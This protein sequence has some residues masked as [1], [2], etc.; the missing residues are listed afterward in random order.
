[1]KLVEITHKITW[2][3]LNIISYAFKSFSKNFGEYI[4][5]ENPSYKNGNI[6][7]KYLNDTWRNQFIKVK[8]SLLE[9]EKGFIELKKKR[10]LKDRKVKIKREIEE[11]FLKPIIVSTDEI[12]Q[13]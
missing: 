11:L 1:M 6:E 10:E 5:M 9:L 13:F 8:N 2:I 4:R 12:N 7:R 3:I